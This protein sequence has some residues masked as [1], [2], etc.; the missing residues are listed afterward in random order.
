MLP[1]LEAL[2]DVLR[3]PLDLLLPD[4]DVDELVWEELELDV[5]E[6]EEGDLGEERRLL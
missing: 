5:C 1:S 2:E 6:E 4:D 3:V